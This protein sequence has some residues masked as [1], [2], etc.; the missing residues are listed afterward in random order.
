[1]SEV[2]ELVDKCIYLATQKVLVTDINK[3]MAECL[4]RY[5]SSKD[6]FSAKELADYSLQRK[7]IQAGQKALEKAI[8]HLASAI[9]TKGIEN[10][11]K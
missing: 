7:E 4:K 8:T 5:E 11:I 6:N 2:Q 3:K 9:K 1:M 10:C